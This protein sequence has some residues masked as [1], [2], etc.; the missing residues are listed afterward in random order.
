MACSPTFATCSFSSALWGAA[1][2]ARE[3]HELALVIHDG[4]SHW[5]VL[6]LLLHFLQHAIH[7]TTGFL[8][9][10]YR[11]LEWHGEASSP[12]ETPVHRTTLPSRMAVLYT[13]PCPAV[14]PPAHTSVLRSRGTE[15]QG[16]GAVP[17]P[18]TPHHGAGSV[19]HERYPSTD[20]LPPTDY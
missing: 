19:R 4:D 12:D 3:A 1:V 6:K 14:W 20:H 15:N 11:L 17:P 16:K 8:E 7:S 5:A 10:E 18:L 9:A 13:T 2:L